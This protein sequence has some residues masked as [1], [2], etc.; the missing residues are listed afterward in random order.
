MNGTKGASYS[1]AASAG[2]VLVIGKRESVGRP[3]RL[4]CRGLRIP[5]DTTG[6]LEQTVLDELELGIHVYVV[7]IWTRE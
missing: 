1:A 7:F 5:L 3:A 2:K 6:T 4:V